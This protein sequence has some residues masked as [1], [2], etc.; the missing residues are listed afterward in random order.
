MFQIIMKKKYQA[1][2]NKKNQYYHNL[3]FDISHFSFRL[4]SNDFF[5]NNFSIQYICV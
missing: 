3:G 4:I 2:L 5:C 1:I